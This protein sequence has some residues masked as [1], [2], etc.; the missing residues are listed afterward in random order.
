[1]R[2]VVICPSVRLDYITD[3]GL[4]ISPACR[5]PDTARAFWD[6]AVGW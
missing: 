6:Q 2:Q 4:C 5:I 3:R 1:M